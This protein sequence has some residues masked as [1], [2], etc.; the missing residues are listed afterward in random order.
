MYEVK[1]LEKFPE[2]YDVL[3]SQTNLKW[4]QSTQTLNYLRISQLSISDSI[5]EEAE[6]QK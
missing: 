3:R 4:L 2:C 1:Y 5:K 6:M